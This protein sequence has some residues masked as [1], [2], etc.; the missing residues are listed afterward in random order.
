MLLAS[1]VFIPC[2]T[3]P[4]CK[5]Q[6]KMHVIKIIVVGL[7]SCI[8]CEFENISF[9]LTII[10]N[11]VIHLIYACRMSNKP[12]SS[13]CRKPLLSG[14]CCLSQKEGINPQKP[15]GW[16]CFCCRDQEQTSVVESCWKTQIRHF[17]KKQITNN[18]STLQMP[19][20]F[21]PFQTRR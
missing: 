9:L 19:F 21:F 3:S 2:I 17:F 12:F 18:L 11:L 10:S 7:I 1:L 20:F 5:N 8:I 16:K 15:G 13:Q 4:K 14:S 6:G